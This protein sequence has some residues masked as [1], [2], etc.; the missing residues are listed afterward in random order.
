MRLEVCVRWGGRWGNSGQ[1]NLELLWDPSKEGRL[2]KKDWVAEETAG[3]LRSG[4][5]E[6][7]ISGSL[8][9]PRKASALGGPGGKP[10]QMS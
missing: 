8:R 10:G 2:L 6:A 9:Q 1:E 7:T 3:H 5:S 4:G